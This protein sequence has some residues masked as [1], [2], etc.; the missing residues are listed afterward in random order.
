MLIIVILWA[1]M[2]LCVSQPVVVWRCVLTHRVLFCPQWEVEGGESQIFWRHRQRGTLLH[3]QHHPDCSASRK[4]R[5]EHRGGA[6]SRVKGQTV[7]V[8]RFSSDMWDTFNDATE[9]TFLINPVKTQ[10]HLLHIWISNS[11]PIHIFCR[12]H[13]THTT[14]NLKPQFCVCQTYNSA[15]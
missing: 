10:W 14:H 3:I 11:I 5:R 12:P 15:L 1:N 13:S 2:Y 7:L 4:K 8:T 6:F 9:G